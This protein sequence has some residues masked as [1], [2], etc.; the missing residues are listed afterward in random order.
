M[1]KETLAKTPDALQD[2]D[3]KSLG[4]RESTKSLELAHKVVNGITES[5]AFF[6]AAIEGDLYVNDT[7]NPAYLE[8]MGAMTKD[9]VGKRKDLFTPEQLVAI[10]AIGTAPYA[11]HQQKLLNQAK[12]GL[13]REEIDH[14]KDTLVEHNGNLSKLLRAYPDTPI[15]TL[16]N[17]I[18]LVAAEKLQDKGALLH[19][20]VSTHLRGMRMENTFEDIVSAARIPLR[21]GDAKEERRGI[22]FVV[23]MPGSRTLHVDIKKSLDEVAG[24][25]G[26]YD[27]QSGLTYARSRDG[28]FTFFPYATD[29]CFVDNSSR[30][31]SELEPQ[32]QQQ[33][34]SALHEMSQQ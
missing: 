18:T 24:K 20:D 7:S 9:Y 25:H 14:A 17:N 16:A 6:D 27:Y 4:D 30:L 21:H 28:K 15:E 13:S 12:E 3:G 33:V 1:T 29:S 19:R 26:N 11:M 22:D 2:D 8:L 10:E 34:L 32:I 31:D 23:D 5:D